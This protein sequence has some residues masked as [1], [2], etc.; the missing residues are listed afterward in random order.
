MVHTSKYCFTLAWY[1]FHQRNLCVRAVTDAPFDPADP[2]AS[3]LPPSIYSPV[4]S[5]LVRSTSHRTPSSYVR[6]KTCEIPLSI[7]VLAPLL[8]YA[9]ALVNWGIPSIVPDS[10]MMFQSHPSYPPSCLLRVS[11]LWCHVSSEFWVGNRFARGGCSIP[12]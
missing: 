2:C 4:L 5:F 9:A 10:V 11:D 7:E 8:L 6:V 12:Y 1:P 3:F